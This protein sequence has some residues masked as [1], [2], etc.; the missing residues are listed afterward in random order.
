MDEPST[1]TLETIKH[2]EQPLK[3]IPASEKVKYLKGSGTLASPIF[4]KLE[5]KTWE[6][7]IQLLEPIHRFDFIGKSPSMPIT[8]N[9]ESLGIYS[10]IDVGGEGEAEEYFTITF[11]ALS[12]L[13][14]PTLISHQIKESS[15]NIVDEKKQ[16]LE[17]CGYVVIKGNLLFANKE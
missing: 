6:D 17:D 10:P 3:K 9:Y 8:I 14:Y 16:F 15:I 1:D 2:T 5:C 4:F 7:F 12:G 13:T 11:T